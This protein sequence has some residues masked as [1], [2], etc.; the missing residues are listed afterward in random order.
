[1]SGI[2]EKAQKEQQIEKGLVKIIDIWDKKEFTYIYDNNLGTFLLGPIE[3]II[4][5]LEGDINILGTM[6]ANR[7]V[8]HFADKVSLWQKNLGG[9]DN[10]MNKWMEI[11]RQWASLYPI[12]ILSADIKEQLPDDAKNF[13]GADTLYRMMMNKAHNYVNVIEVICTDII[14]TQ[15]GRQDELEAMLKYIG[16]ILKQCDTALNDYLETKRAGFAR[17]YF[18]SNDELLEIL[19]QSKHFLRC[20]CTE[21]FSFV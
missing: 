19:S 7:F 1:M 2:V 3:E 4:E 14:K 10:C 8:E 9:V 11:Q 16:Q 17:F 5:Q 6:Q 15:L 18:L 20:G 12:F 13:S 21:S